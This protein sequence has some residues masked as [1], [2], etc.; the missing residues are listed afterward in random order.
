M[1][2]TISPCLKAAARSST[3]APKMLTRF[4]IISGDSEGA[5]NISS[6]LRV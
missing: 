4:M 3:S 5:F 1:V 6:T 2:T